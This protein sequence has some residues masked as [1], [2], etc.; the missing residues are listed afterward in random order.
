[1]QF[2]NVHRVF[3]TFIPATDM[4]KVLKF[5]NTVEYACIPENASV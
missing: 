3:V 5:W 1:M 2:C 4:K